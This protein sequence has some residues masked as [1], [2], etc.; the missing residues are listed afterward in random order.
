MTD[1][2]RQIIIHFV[3]MLR[4]IILHFTTL[5]SIAR[6]RVQNFVAEFDPHNDIVR[7]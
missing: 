2:K 7:T 6:K 3:G 4:G 1:V 5:I